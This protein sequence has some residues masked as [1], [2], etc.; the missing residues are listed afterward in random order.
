LIFVTS[1]AAREEPVSDVLPADL[2]DALAVSAERLPPG[3]RV[4][5]HREVDST[6]DLALALAA[7]DAPHGTVV[8]ADA[9]RAGRGRRGRA[10]FSPPGAGLYV[11][12][13]VRGE[14][15]AALP[16]LTLAAGAATAQAVATTTGLPV[17]LKWPNDLVIGRPWRKLAGILCESTGAASLD[18]VVVGIGVNL[19]PAAY[20]PELAGVATSIEMELGRAVERAP[21]VAEMLALLYAAAR[22]LGAG[23][24]GE[25]LARW[26]EFGYSGLNGAAV[27]WHEQGAER[28]GRARDLDDAGALL[29]ESDGRIERIIAGEVTWDQTR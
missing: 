9:Q 19:Q 18:A 20:P 21:L 16:L 29:V 26:R 1:P 6:N 27:R 14:F 23:N 17:E 8:L 24:R 11:S 5:W 7:R 4:S 2:A 25:L 12:A 13:I 15:G 3:L 22:E 10:W 28:Q